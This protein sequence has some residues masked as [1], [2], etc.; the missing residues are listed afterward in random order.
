MENNSIKEELF[1]KPPL[2]YNTT[3]AVYCIGMGA[4][5]AANDYKEYLDVFLEN[6]ENIDKD[7]KIVKDVLKKMNSKLTAYSR[8]AKFSEENIDPEKTFD[9][10]E[11]GKDD[12]ISIEKQY[13]RYEAVYQRI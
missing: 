4:C 1:K 13:R 7:T 2:L 12:L 5:F 8:Y 3:E 6:Y 9:L 10:L 11:F